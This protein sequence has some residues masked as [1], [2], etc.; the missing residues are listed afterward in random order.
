MRRLQRCAPPDAQGRLPSGCKCREGHPHEDAAQPQ[1]Q[2]HSTRGGPRRE[3]ALAR[4]G[5]RPA[6]RGTDGRSIRVAVHARLSLLAAGG[7]G[8]P[9]GRWSGGGVRR[10]GRAA[11]V[12]PPGGAR[13]GGARV[14]EARLLHARRDRLL[15]GPSHALGRS[16]R[17]GRGSPGDGARGAHPAVSRPSRDDRVWRPVPAQL[18][19]RLPVGKVR[20][21]RAIP[22]AAAHGR[23]LRVSVLLPQH[24][25]P[26]APSP[27]CLPFQ[28]LLRREAQRCERV[29]DTPRPLWRCCRRR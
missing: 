15:L 1:A 16:A 27:L 9:R 5:A 24:P 14:C 21:T 18:H 2:W 7:D 6:R 8:A 22:D 4:V 13:V 10:L 26:H 25:V 3:Q 29:R 23:R 11:G 12:Q 17:G 28:A 19:V 20:R